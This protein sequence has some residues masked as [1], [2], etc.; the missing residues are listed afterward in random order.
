MMF[1]RIALNTKRVAIDYRGQMENP[2]DKSA[3]AFTSTQKPKQE[4]A[5]AFTAFLPIV[6][7]LL[8]IPA[9][10]FESVLVT[11]VHIGEAKGRRT[12]Q[13]SCMRTIPDTN[14]P[15]NFTTPLLWE[16]ADGD[17]SEGRLVWPKGLDEA[18]TKIQ[19][20]AS[21]YL[22]GA[23]EQG[24]LFDGP[25]MASEPDD[26]AAAHEEA[27]QSLPDP[28]FDDVEAGVSG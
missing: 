6:R 4:F 22:S 15:F 28:E 12:V 2:K 7:K 24:D 25:V 16:P 10:W 17:E 19:A 13:V 21:A 23:R 3:T 26:E 14:A 1:S 5:D 18:L 20:Q 9:A 27:V 8:G 11:A